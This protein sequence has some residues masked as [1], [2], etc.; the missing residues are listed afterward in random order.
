MEPDI[1]LTKKN[2]A[3]VADALSQVLA[4]TYALYQKTHV[5]HWNV[6]GP[7]FPELHVLFE[8]QYRELWTALDTIAERVRA[9][10]VMAPGPAAV[11]KR[12]G[13]VAD[14]GAASAPQMVLNLLK[15][16]ETLVKAA[17]GALRKADEIGDDATVDLMTQRAAASEKAAWMLR[18]TAESG[19]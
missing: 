2:R 7:R 16:H 17:R 9:L 4:D 15:G 19:E 8:Q 3:E 6:T 5:Y 11:G 14:N 12:T 13:I 10:G 1:G 18:A